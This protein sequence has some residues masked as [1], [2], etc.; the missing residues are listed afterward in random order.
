MV[1]CCCFAIVVLCCY[2]CFVAC[3]FVIVVLCCCI[4]VCFCSLRTVQFNLSTLRGSRGGTLMRSF[5][6]GFWGS[7]LVSSHYFTVS[8]KVGRVQVDNQLKYYALSN[9]IVFAAEKT[10]EPEKCKWVGMCPGLPQNFLRP[11]RDY[12][13]TWNYPLSSSP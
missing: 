3:C 12:W 8:A 2:Y 11:S 4:V 5:N 1:F 10:W 13:N 7:F 9:R 6:P